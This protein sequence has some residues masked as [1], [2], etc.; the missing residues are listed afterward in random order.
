MLP[1]IWVPCRKDSFPLAAS[2]LWVYSECCWVL[3]SFRGWLSRKFDT[4]CYALVYVTAIMIEMKRV[5]SL[6]PRIIAWICM[7][8]IPMAYSC[9]SVLILLLFCV[10]NLAQSVLSLCYDVEDLYVFLLYY[11]RT[12]FSEVLLLVW[13]SPQ[14]IA[15]SP[16][17]NYWLQE[18]KRTTFCHSPVTYVHNQLVW[19]L[20]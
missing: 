14:N 10:W 20:G 18:I 11:C 4:L 7:I 15:H 13:L 17:W 19:W 9:M 3:N 2:V 5:V 16:C 8:F 6:L 1:F 12:C